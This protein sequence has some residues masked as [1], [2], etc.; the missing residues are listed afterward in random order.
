MKKS[1]V[2]A[3]CGGPIRSWN[4]SGLCAKTKAC[5]KLGVA[6]S[7]SRRRRSKA[8]KKAGLRDRGVP[9]AERSKL[10]EFL[11]ENFPGMIQAG[12]KNGMTAVDVAIHILTITKRYYQVADEDEPLAKTRLTG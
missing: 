5:L 3:N 8:G 6:A 10:A 12:A 11:Y 1:R 2:C 9:L 7:V 4:R